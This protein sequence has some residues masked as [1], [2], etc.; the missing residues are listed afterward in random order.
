MNRKLR[1]SRRQG[2]KIY[3]KIH[4]ETP[5][6]RYEISFARL[7]SRETSYIDRWR[8]YGSDWYDYFHAKEI[9]CVLTGR[10]P[11]ILSRRRPV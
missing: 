8:R 1:C 9:R 4:G 10:I 2:K 5:H 11:A 3:A 6:S 7:T